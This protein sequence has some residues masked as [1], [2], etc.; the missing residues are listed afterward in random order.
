MLHPVAA[1]KQHAVLACHQATVTSCGCSC[2]SLSKT[3]KTGSSGGYQPSVRSA[4]DTPSSAGSIAISPADVEI[5][6]HP[7]GRAWVLGAGNF[8]RVSSACCTQLLLI[9]HILC[10]RPVSYSSNAVR[11]R[12][13]GPCAQVYRG[14]WRGHHD[15]AIK[16]LTCFA[17]EMLLSALVRHRPRP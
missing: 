3:A 8:G 4:S 11:S 16:Q 14:L 1:R 2:C 15:V 17:D 7:D 10:M 5:C 13:A 9:W 6:H 12:G